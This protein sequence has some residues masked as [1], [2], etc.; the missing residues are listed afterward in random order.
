MKKNLLLLLI[1]LFLSG[2]QADAPL[3]DRGSF[4]LD[5]SHSGQAYDAR[6]RFL[7]VH[8]TAGDFPTSLSVLTDEHVSAHYL[9]PAQ[10]PMRQGK[11][12]AWQLVDE[13][14]AAWHAGASAWRGYTRL[15]A[16]SI[17]IELE[18]P[19]YRQTLVGTRWSPYP[20]QQIA[21]FSALAQ[22]IIARYHIPAQNVVAHS[23]IAPLRKQDPGPLFPWRAL[24]QSGIGA[25]PDDSRVRFYLNGRAAEEPVAPAVLVDKLLRYGY[26]VPDADNAR[27]QRQLIAAFQMHFRPENHQGQADAESDA[28][29]DALLDK[30]GAA[31]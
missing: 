25:W 28:I 20:A 15:N 24:A 6:V 19:G 26:S 16:S 13:S 1:A 10:P 31:R 30:Y 17:G 7:V 23:D 3:V 18:N 11:P 2:C 29:A 4:L 27:Q 5:A 8:Y 21:L 22:Q 9:V 14:Q 12:I